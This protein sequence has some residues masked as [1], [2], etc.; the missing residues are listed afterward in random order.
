MTSKMV[1][2]ISRDSPYRS[3]EQQGDM[4]SPNIENTLRS[5]KAEIRSCKAKND[6]IIQAQEKQAKVNAII[7]Q[8]LLDM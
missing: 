4:H 6:R 3:D 1:D 8:S 7:F 5:L 2:N